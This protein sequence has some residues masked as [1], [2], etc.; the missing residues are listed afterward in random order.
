MSEEE[1]L[2]IENCQ[3]HGL[4]GAAHRIEC[5]IQEVVCILYRLTESAVRLGN[6]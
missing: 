3:L 4:S 6:A 1:T 2:S 5:W